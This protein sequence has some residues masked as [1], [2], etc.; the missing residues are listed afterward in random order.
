MP[1]SLRDASPPSVA[2]TLVRTHRACA[3]TPSSEATVQRH[4]LRSRQRSAQCGPCAPLQEPTG[5]TRTVC[6]GAALSMPPLC[7][8]SASYWNEQNTEQTHS[9]AQPAARRCASNGCFLVGRG[10][11]ASTPE[12]GPKTLAPMR[13]RLA[14]SQLSSLSAQSMEARRANRGRPQQAKAQPPQSRRLCRR[15]PRRA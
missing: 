14:R 10:N 7:G 1:P 3:S 11:H 6:G 12:V 15:R 2:E 13:G 9:S 8:V 4:T 5:R